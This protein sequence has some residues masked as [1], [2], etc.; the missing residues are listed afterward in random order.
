MDNVKLILVLVILLLDVIACSKNTEPS[1]QNTVN[2]KT[3]ASAYEVEFTDNSV[4]KSN[5]VNCQGSLTA[6]ALDQSGEA[7]TAKSL[8]IRLIDKSG[9]EYFTLLEE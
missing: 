3:Y 8:T 2:C 5:V 9:V 4:R 1:A 6:T 7:L